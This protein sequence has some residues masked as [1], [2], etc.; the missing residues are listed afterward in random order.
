MLGKV[1]S[2]TMEGSMFD[3]ALRF[4]GGPDWHHFHVYTDSSFVA[5]LLVAALLLAILLASAICYYVTRAIILM[6]V[7]RLA[8]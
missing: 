4:E 1:G 3:E 5:V 8:R 6:I 7:G 2:P